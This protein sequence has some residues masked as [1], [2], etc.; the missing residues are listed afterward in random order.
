MSGIELEG[1]GIVDFCS[2]FCGA[3]PSAIDLTEF[4]RTVQGLQIQ[5]DQSILN[6]VFGYLIEVQNKNFIQKG[7]S[8]VNDD[9]V[10]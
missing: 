10:S 5:V 4:E 6:N 8:F 2:R 3:Q 7:L 9:H 1:K